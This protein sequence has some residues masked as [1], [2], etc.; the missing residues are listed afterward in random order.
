MDKTMLTLKPGITL[1]EQNG[2]TGLTLHGRVQYAKDA[3]QAEILRALVEQPQ[4]LEN[5]MA[6]LQTGNGLPGSDH[7]VSLAIAGF[8]LDFG[9]YLET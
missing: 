5:L 9:E 1:T 2:Q 8:I 3:R 4:S 7:D 6:I